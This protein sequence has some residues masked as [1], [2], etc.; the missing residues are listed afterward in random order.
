MKYTAKL[1]VRPD[2]RCS[3]LWVPAFRSCQSCQTSAEVETGSIKRTRA[4]SATKGKKPRNGNKSEMSWKTGRQVSERLAAIGT[5][6]GNKNTIFV[7]GTLPTVSRKA[8]RVMAENTSY[9]TDRLNREISRWM[10]GKKFARVLVWE[11]QK[12]G[13]LHF[14]LVIAARHLGDSNLEAM[15][16]RFALVWYRVLESL[17]LSHGASMMRNSKGKDWSLRELMEIDLGEHFLNLQVV[18]KSVVAYLSKYLSE[19]K[20]GK[21][22]KQKQKLRRMFWPIKS[23]ATW[24]RVATKIRDL[25]VHEEQ[26]GSFYGCNESDFEKECMDA[27]ASLKL[28]EGTNVK[29]PR[30]KFVKGFYFLIDRE[31]KNWLE[32]LRESVSYAIKWVLAK[33]VKGKLPTTELIVAKGVSVSIDQSPDESH[34]RDELEERYGLLETRI[35]VRERA[36]ALGKELAIFGMLLISLGEDWESQM[37]DYTPIIYTQL[38]LLKEDDK[39]KKRD[40]DRRRLRGNEDESKRPSRAVGALP[41]GPPTKTPRRTP[42]YVRRHSKDASR[43]RES[44]VRQRLGSKEIGGRRIFTYADIRT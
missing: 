8:F 40:P 42:G 31:E 7:T 30:N 23:W 33:P 6:F 35:A 22:K 12:R 25:Y 18:R 2:G 32:D 10:D 26:V 38:E 41:S 16:R 27:I 28:V 9:A 20:K 34:I 3:I 29:T 37:R 15:R 1:S 4:E 21:D 19:S 5:H 43:R 17:Q 14:H 44:N 39:T 24:N 11:Y 36:K 13:A